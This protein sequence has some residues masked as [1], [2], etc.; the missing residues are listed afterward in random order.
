MR[1]GDSPSSAASTHTVSTARW[2]HHPFIRATAIVSSHTFDTMLP[3]VSYAREM[4]TGSSFVFV[5]TTKLP[6]S[7]HSELN[8]S[9]LPTRRRTTQPRGAAVTHLC[10]KHTRA[11]RKTTYRN[12]KDDTAARSSNLEI[13]EVWYLEARPS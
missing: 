8:A 13:L 5:V 7:S 3:A 4:P 10:S 9:P 6:A 2:Q 12:P 1:W 11:N